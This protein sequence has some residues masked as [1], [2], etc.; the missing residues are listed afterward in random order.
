[1]RNCSYE[2]LRYIGSSN[3]VTKRQRE[4]LLGH[5]DCVYPASR[6]QQHAD[7]NNRVVETARP[8]SIFRVAAPE[9]RVSF[10]ELEQHRSTRYGPD[11]PRP[12]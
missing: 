4:N 10:V 11:R 5:I 1:M 2:N 8:N 3:S 9:K 7:T 12:A 6:V